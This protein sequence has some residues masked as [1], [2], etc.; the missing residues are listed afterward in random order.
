MS[1]EWYPILDYET[2]PKG[3]ADK[4]LRALSVWVEQRS[5]LS[6]TTLAS[7]RSALN[8]NGQ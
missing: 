5:K 2:E 7:S 4:E 6:E 8:V 1:Q 3:L